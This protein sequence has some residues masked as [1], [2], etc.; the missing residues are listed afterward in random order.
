MESSEQTL[1]AHACRGDRSAVRAVYDRYAPLLA[2]VCARYI[3]D[4]DDAKD[5]LQESFIKIF[6]S[7]SSFVYRG[8]GSLRAWMTRIVVNESLKFLRKSDS[9]VFLT[10]DG[11]LPETADEPEPDV[12]DIPPD[13]IFLLI[14][15]LPPGFRTVFNLYVFEHKTHA[16]IASAL[17]IS[18]S[19]SAS[20][21][22]RAKKYL[23]NAI[24]R[25]RQ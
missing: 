2:A 4:T 1:A 19:T 22:H 7:M 15:Q 14:R 10:D 6:G 18:E 5:V 3:N 9:L 21:L 12:G 17:G 20:Q 16:E 25:L 11:E 24:N 13:R 23:A 8:E